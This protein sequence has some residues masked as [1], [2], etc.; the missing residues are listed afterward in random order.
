MWNNN[1]NRI[2]VLEGVKVYGKSWRNRNDKN[3]VYL[4]MKLLK[5]FKLK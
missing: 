5:K 2:L 4:C 1:N 3:R